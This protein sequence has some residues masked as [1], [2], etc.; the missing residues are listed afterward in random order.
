MVLPQNAAKLY[1]TLLLVY[2][3]E[4]RSEYGAE[5][6]QLFADRLDSEPK[7]RVWAQAL[8]DLAVTAPREHFHVLAA[9]LRYAA[10]FFA[11]APAFTALALTIVALGIGASTAVFSL[12]NAVLLRSL[13]YG[14]PGR[15]VYVWAPNP[16]YKLP[17]G[18]LMSVGN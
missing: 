7:I 8:A 9:D 10:R 12:L 13:P 1:R 5:M 15:L 14:D 4:F 16:R 6:E 18:I 17:A 2:P 3:S 11:K